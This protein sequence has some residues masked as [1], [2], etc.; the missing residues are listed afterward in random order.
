MSNLETIQIDKLKLDLGNYRT[1][2]QKTENDAINTMI[3]ISPDRFWSLMENIIDDGYYPTENIIVLK[4]GKQLIVKEGNRR[5]ASLKI[6]LNQ[7][8]DIEV[9]ESIKEK[10]NNLNKDWKSSN[11]QVPCTIYE[12]NET[13]TV[14]K[15]ISLIHAKG[16]KAGRDPWTAVA[17]AR[18]A[19]EEKKTKEF[20][21]DLLEKY[22]KNGKNLSSSEI[23]RWSANF[24][25]TVL[26]ELLPRLYV[27]AGFPSTE[28]LITEYPRKNRSLIENILYDIGIEK[29][30]FKDIREKNI[31]WGESYGLFEPGKTSSG[32]NDA[33]SNNREDSGGTTNKPT[34]NEK[35]SPVSISLNDPKSVY[36]K[37]KGFK[38]HGDNREKVVALLDEM[39]RLKIPDHPYSFCFLLRS[40]FEVSAKAY[41]ND[42]K[43][44]GLTV[45]KADG[46]DKNLA[47]VL[48]EI[49]AHMTP[50][51]TDREK[52]KTLHGSMTEIAKPDGILSVT[53]LNQL[54]HNTKFSIVPSDICI[55]FWNVFPLL[56]EMNL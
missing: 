26:D 17:R 30:R 5:I 25:L 8:R 43:V 44:D 31:F 18:F 52:K 22:L 32:N 16:E 41:C 48:R 46:N 3:S 47:D 20:G 11:K 7:I 14:K 23:E 34:P 28:E 50:N 37:I 6:I 15:I 10:I 42:H 35:K 36:K 39:K 49:V 1:I 51:K 55:T 56:E 45:I 29:L 4:S 33:D 2:Q 54:I 27:A 12:D 13:E 53:S 40:L 9:P 24:P 21:L 38:P 19:R